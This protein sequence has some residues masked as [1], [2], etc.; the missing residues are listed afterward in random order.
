[1]SVTHKDVKHIASLARLAVPDDKLEAIASQLNGILGHMEVLGKVDTS[2]VNIT[3][4][5]GSSNSGLS[6]STP[7][8]QD[9]GP[10]IPLAIQP[11]SFSPEMF[12]GFFIV[13]R[14]ATHGDSGS[15]SNGSNVK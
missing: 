9:N 13:P 4:G 1:M 11:Q 15:G 10:P 7:L 12:E 2:G 8:R 14:L 6:D 3:T 5:G